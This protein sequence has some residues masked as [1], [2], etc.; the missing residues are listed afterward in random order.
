MS[1]PD[2]LDELGELAL[3]SRIKRL[4]D[5]MMAEA[6]RTYAAFGHDAQPK[7]FALLALLDRRGPVTV[8]EAAESLGLTQPAVSQFLRG[9]EERR[10]IQLGLDPTDGR[11]RVVRLSKRGRAEVAAMK[12]MWRAVDAAA[13]ELCEEAGGHLLEALQR[14]EQAL[15]Q[16]SMAERALEHAH[17][18]ASKD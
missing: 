18:R 14:F 8:V 1:Q 4:G 10:W 13:R 16:R 12:P 15:E 6:G 2:F 3:G 9:L 7:W 5:R 17:E 11:K